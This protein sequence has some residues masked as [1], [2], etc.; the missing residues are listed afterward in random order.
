M[1]KELNDDVRTKQEL[2]FECSS[3]ESR[4][5]DEIIKNEDLEQQVKKQ[6]QAID[7]ARKYFEENYYDCLDFNSGKKYKKLYHPEKLYELLKE[8]S[9]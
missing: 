5:S 4:L 7:K 8:V 3:L 2:L 9:K 1:D 6:Q